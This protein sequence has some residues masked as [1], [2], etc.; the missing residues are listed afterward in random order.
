MILFI[1]YF[2]YRLYDRRICH[3]RRQVI[4]ILVDIEANENTFQSMIYESVKDDLKLTCGYSH[5]SF[6]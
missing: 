2:F 4:H 1:Y 5:V 3:L 6:Q